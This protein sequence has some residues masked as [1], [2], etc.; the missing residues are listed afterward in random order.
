M[1][2]ASS[3]SQDLLK[4]KKIIFWQVDLKS[5]LVSIID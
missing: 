4:E 1:L 3:D 5:L 2:V